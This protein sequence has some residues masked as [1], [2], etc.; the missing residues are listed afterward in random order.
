MSGQKRTRKRPNPTPSRSRTIDPVPGPERPAKRRSTIET[1]SNQPD[2]RLAIDFGTKYTTVAC[3]RGSGTGKAIFTIQEFPDDPTPHR[4]DR[5]VPTEITYSQDRTQALKITYGYEIERQREFPDGDYVEL[6]HVTNVKLLLDKSSY[7]KPMRKELMEVL[8]K[9]KAAQI[10]KKDEKV[11]FD[12]LVCYLQHTKDILRRDHG[13]DNGSKVEITFCVPVCWNPSANARMSACLQEAMRKVHLGVDN[14]GVC[15]LF[16]VNEAEAAATY[17]LTSTFYPPKGGEVF[18]LLD[19]GGGTTDVGVYT[20]GREYPFRL[21]REVTPAT[22]VVCGSGDL[23][24]RFREFSVQQLQKAQIPEKDTFE[25]ERIVDSDLMPRFENLVKRSFSLKAKKADRSPLY[26]FPIRG[27][28]RVEGNSRIRDNSF[29]LSFEDMEKI[30]MPSLTTI[31]NLMEKQISNALKYANV[32]KV[33]LAGGFG[34][35]PA[36]KEAITDTLIRINE[37]HKTNIKLLAAPSNTGAVGVATGALLRAQNKEYGPARVP[38]QSIGIYQ[39]I[40]NEPH[41]YSDEVL[42]HDEDDWKVLIDGQRYIEK[43]IKWII[44][45]G[46]GEFEPVHEFEWEDLQVFHRLSNN[47]NAEHDL[48]ASDVCTEDFYTRSHARNWGK[49]FYIGKVVFNLMPLKEHIELYVP[50][51]GEDG[52]ERFECKILIKMKLIDKH[53]DFTAYWPADG[54]HLIT[55]KGCHKH[56]NVVSAFASGTA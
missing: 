51:N 15:N 38:C 37:T 39:H 33:A 47:W 8:K 35:S 26:P 45:V 40:R 32:D 42:D 44:K 18:V 9:L 17:T 6:G 30:F 52:E 5:Q 50:K 48:F 41:L 7:L 2:F 34:D 43:T 29:V 14:G 20:I 23:N 19:C 31:S 13:L 36:L 10:I 53:L 54:P 49:T 1:T 25:T 24:R 3:A 56:I 28:Q 11:I 22:G 21:G 12:L 55:I 4:A 16:M 27:L 46:E